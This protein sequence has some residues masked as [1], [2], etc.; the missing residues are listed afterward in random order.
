MLTGKQRTS[1]VRSD[2]ELRRARAEKPPRVMRGSRLVAGYFLPHW[3]KKARSKTGF[4]KFQKPHVVV[5]D[6]MQP[7]T[8]IPH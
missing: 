7:L 3:H 5:G 2:L 4:F 1:A 8:S 6:L